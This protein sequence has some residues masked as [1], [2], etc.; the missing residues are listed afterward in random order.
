MR[1]LNRHF[2]FKWKKRRRDKH[3]ARCKVPN[4]LYC[5]SEKVLGI[6]DKKTKSEN[7]K[8]KNERFSD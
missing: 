2:T 8:L 4:C 7:E 1:A 5:H 3:G 6:P